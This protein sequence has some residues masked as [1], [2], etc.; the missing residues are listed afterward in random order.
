MAPV[1]EA[2]G[3]MEPDVTHAGKR[4]NGLVGGAG[5]GVADDPFGAQ[6]DAQLSRS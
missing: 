2:T 5:G 4:W 6:I 3:G 1:S